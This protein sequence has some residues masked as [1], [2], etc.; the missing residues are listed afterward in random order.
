MGKLTTAKLHA[1]CRLA[2]KH[3]QTNREIHRLFE[4]RY[5]TGYNEIDEDWLIDSLDYGSGALVSLKECDELMTQN[6]YPPLSH[7]SGG[8]H[9]GE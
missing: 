7:P 5:G 4:E 6:G 2:W 3:T 1:A 9:H 8:D